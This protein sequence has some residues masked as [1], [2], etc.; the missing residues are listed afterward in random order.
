LASLTNFRAGNQSIEA[1]L[2]DSITSAGSRFYRIRK[3]PAP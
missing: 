1:V 3:F 2:T